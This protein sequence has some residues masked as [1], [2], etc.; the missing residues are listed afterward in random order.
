VTADSKVSKTE[1]VIH[2]V[3]PKPDAGYWG[4]GP[5]AALSV[6]VGDSVVFRTGAGFHDVASVPT[7]K[8]FADCDMSGMTQLASWEP[9]KT[10]GTAACN[11][12]SVCCAGSACGATG[13]YVTYTWKPTA[14][15]DTYFVCSMSGGHHC[16]LGQKI[17]VT[18]KAAEAA[19]SSTTSAANNAGRCMMQTL[20][21][22]CFLAMS[23]VQGF[24][25]DQH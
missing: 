3:K 9:M 6:N 16:K 8:A 20:F 13:Y 19:A 24:L 23:P 12:S 22:I 10:T 2:A 15:G 4:Q 1:G 5:Y 18:V 14:A 21:A 11:S 25:G 7:S 17:K